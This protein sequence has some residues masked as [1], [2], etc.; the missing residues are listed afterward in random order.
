[1]RQRTDESPHTGTDL[2]PEAAETL[3]RALHSPL[4]GKLGITLTDIGHGT[5][6]LHMPFDTTNTTVGDIVHGGAI[7]SLADTAAT[8]AIWSTVEDPQSYRGLTIDLSLS[9][10]SAARGADLTADARILKRGR[11][12]CYSEVDV[13]APDGEL[14]ARAT[15]AYKLSRLQPG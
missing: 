12:I 4:A 11:S 3:R 5:A 8:A 10:L 13:T 1:M 6:R 7:L 9:F 15:V 14:V 2:A